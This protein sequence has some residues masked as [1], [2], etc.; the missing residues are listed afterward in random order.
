MVSANAFCDFKHFMSS[1]IPSLTKSKQNTPFCFSICGYA[2]DVWF[3]ISTYATD[4][5]L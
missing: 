1:Y 5:L 4:G 2:F 3:S